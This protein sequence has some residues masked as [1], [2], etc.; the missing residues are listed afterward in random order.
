MPDAIPTIDF[1]SIDFPTDRLTVK[2]LRR[3]APHGFDLPVVGTALGELREGT[4]Y[5]RDSLDAILGEIVDVEREIAERAFH[6]ALG[7]ACPVHLMR[8]FPDAARECLAAAYLRLQI[9]GVDHQV[10][11]LIRDIENQAAVQAERFLGPK[12]R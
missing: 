7:T 9:A 12:P 6:Q 4:Y 2:E 1:T 3:L 5:R 11:Q 10:E 8:G